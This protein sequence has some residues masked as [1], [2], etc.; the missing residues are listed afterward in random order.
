M[1]PFSSLVLTEV[2]AWRVELM[3]KMVRG[4]HGLGLHVLLLSIAVLQMCTWV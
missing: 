3:L 4:R 2:L 1:Y